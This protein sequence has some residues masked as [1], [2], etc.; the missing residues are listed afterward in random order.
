VL[1]IFEIGSH[2]LFTQGWLLTVILLISASQVAR[3]TGVSHGHPAKQ[4]LLKG[5]K[6]SEFK[7]DG[8]F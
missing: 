3:I 4:Q 5:Q 6:H 7:T 8:E 1:G 2:K